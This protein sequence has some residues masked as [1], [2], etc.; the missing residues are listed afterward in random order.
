MELMPALRFEPTT[1]ASRRP[2]LK[3]AIRARIPKLQPPPPRLPAD[4]AFAPDLLKFYREAAG[5]ASLKR[6][7]RHGFQHVLSPVKTK[8][9][10]GRAV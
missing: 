5:K 1:V 3:L 2:N 9:Y 4:Q 10:E 8:A 6:V 7:V